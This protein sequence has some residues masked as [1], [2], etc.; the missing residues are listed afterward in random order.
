MSRTSPHSTPLNLFIEDYEMLD[1]VDGEHDS[2]LYPFIRYRSQ[3][4]V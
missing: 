1:S 4:N 2:V 3:I